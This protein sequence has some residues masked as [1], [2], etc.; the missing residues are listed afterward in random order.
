MNTFSEYY[1]EPDESKAHPH[2]LVLQMNFNPT[3][4]TS[5][6]CADLTLLVSDRDSSVGRATRYKLDGP[7]FETWWG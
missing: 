2:S 5:V 1:P 3:M 4:P 6:N 7:V